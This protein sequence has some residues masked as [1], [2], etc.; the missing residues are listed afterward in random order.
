L[1]EIMP[2]LI[3]FDVDKTLIERIE[4]HKEAFSHAFKQ[5]YGVETSVD[6]I[7]HAGKTDRQ[8]IV[9]VLKQEGLKESEILSKIDACIES[10]TDYF[11]RVK[12]VIQIEAFDGIS[13]LLTQLNEAGFLLGLVT[14]NLEPIA[15]GKL[16]Q[17]GLNHFFKLGGFGSDD[18]DR[19]QLVRLAIKRAREQFDFKANNN[20]FLLGDTPR[21]IA[22]GKAAEVTTIGVATGNYSEEELVEADAD[23]VLSNLSSEQKVLNLVSRS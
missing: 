19:S 23:H 21:D 18:R 17:V 6:A 20:V 16:D 4:G 8:I 13:H 11:N 9:E 5:V 14:G 15:R 12:D 1:I 2:G 22:A 3:L 7:D 10:M